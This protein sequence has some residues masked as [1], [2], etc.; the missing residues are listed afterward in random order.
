MGPILVIYFFMKNKKYF[1]IFS[2]VSAGVLFSILLGLCFLKGVNF[3]NVYFLNVG[4]GDSVL[5]RTPE[6]RNILIDGGPDNLVLHRLGEVLPFYIRRLDYIIISHFHDDH[7]S[8]LIEILKRYQIKKIIFAPSD[9]SSPL[10]LAFF[11]EIENKNIS[12]IEIKNTASLHL[13]SYCDLFFIN[14]GSLK[15]KNNDNNS[16]VA[17]LNC[18]GKTFLFAGDNEVEAEKALV[19]SSFDLKADIFKASHHGSKTSNTEEFLKAVN[20]EKIIISV[21]HDNRFGHPSREVLER[22]ISNKIEVIRTDVLG[23]IHILANIQ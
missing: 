21:G 4:Q 18:R 6:H 23:T 8:G 7:I 20:P 14:S 13:D 15:I 16:L 10:T 2:I 22:V 1:L 3:L 9:I 19:A 5:I 12:I 17:K 11:K